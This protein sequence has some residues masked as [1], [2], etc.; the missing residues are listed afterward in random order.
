MNGYSIAGNLLF[1]LVAETPDRELL[2]FEKLFVALTEASKHFLYMDG[3]YPIRLKKMYAR[4]MSDNTRMG[5]C[6]GRVPEND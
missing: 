2:P 5:F 6:I 4:S 1:A 3:S